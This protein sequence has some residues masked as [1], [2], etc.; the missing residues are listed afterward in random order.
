MYYNG[1]GVV[2]DYAEAEKWFRL[3]A[4]QG[5]ANAQYNLGVLY[6]YGQGVVQD[7]A[8]G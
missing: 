5:I 3:A 1:Q 6:H 7:Y 4:A 8:V 2:Q